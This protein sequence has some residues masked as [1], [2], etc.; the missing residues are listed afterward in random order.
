MTAAHPALADAARV[1]YWLDRPE[2]PDPL[3]P[4]AGPTSA[5]L[6]VVGGG[7]SGLWAALLARQADPGREVLLVEAGTCGWAASGRN[8]GFCAASLTHG[9]ANGAQRFP[10]EID[11]LERLG[12][13]NLA[14]IEATVAEHR[15]DCD[16]E[17]TGELAVAVEPYQLAG[18]AQDAALARRYGHDVT[19]LDREQVRAEVNSPTYL[20][21]LSDRDRVAMLDPARLAWG[22]RRACLDAG[23]R[24]HE[25]TRVTGLR[26][27]G[28]ALH[29]RTVGADDLPGS[30]RAGRVVLATNAFPPLLRRLRAWTVP[31]YDYALMTEPLR[32]EQRAAVGWR[33]RQGLT[34]TGNQFHYYRITGDNRILFGGY[35]AVYHYGNRVAP[36][37]EQRE[38]TFAALA[39]HFFATFPQLDGL[40]FS[41]R[42]GGVI[43]TCTR[44][45]PFFG[46]AY[47]GRLAYAA[48]YTGLGVGATRFGARVMLDLLDG[49]D[50]PLTRLGLVRDKPLPFPPEPVRAAGIG[51]TR[52]SLA[53]ADARQGRRNLWLRTLDRLG[54]GFDS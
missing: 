23:V 45:C 28:G 43:D 2:R 35:D 39:E 17:R 8:G 19:L 16:F 14:A 50:T 32:P 41:H 36:A 22:L 3:P 7:Y 40:R 9:L 21:G 37:L 12:R 6:L 29:A 24:I 42:W 46:T 11:E 20:G 33:N 26:R 31:V 51:L 13:E 4:L 10:G 30:V 34:D 25:H 1:P 44:F 27:D 53:R 5:D 52:W 47:D 48:G 38:A 18:L 54:L 49:A 15:I